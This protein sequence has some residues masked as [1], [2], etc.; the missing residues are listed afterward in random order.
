MPSSSYDGGL[1]ATTATAETEAEA[2]AVSDTCWMT[3]PPLP[4]YRLAVS[5]NLGEDRKLPDDT[6]SH[7]KTNLALVSIEDGKCTEKCVCL[8]RICNE[9]MTTLELLCFGVRS[10]CGTTKAGE[11]VKKNRKQ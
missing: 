2:A 1:S 9:S 11:V 8:T 4:P 6:A 10:P 3:R 7:S 5:V